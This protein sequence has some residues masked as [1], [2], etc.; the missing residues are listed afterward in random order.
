MLRLFPNSMKHSDS[1]KHSQKK[2]E[3]LTIGAL[4]FDSIRSPAGEVDQIIGGA[5]NYFSIA[6]SFFSRIH[7]VGIVG[8]DFPKEHLTLLSDRG[9]DV[10]GV[11]V[12]QDG[13][14][15]HWVGEY[16]ENLNEAKTLSTR[17]NV[18]ERFNPVLNSG[19]KASHTVFLANNDPGLQG[20]IL[21]QMTDPRFVG[22]D[23]MNFWITGKHEDL[24]KVLRRVDLLSINEGEACLLSKKKSLLES[25]RAVQAMGPSIL[26]IKR[27]EYGSALF[28]GDEIFLAPAYP[29]DRVIDPTGA[30]DSFAGALMGYLAEAGVDREW[31]RTNPKKLIHA[32]KRG[33]LFGS[34]MASFTVEDFGL[35]RLLRLTKE[36]LVKRHERL[37]QMIAVQD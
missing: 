19:Q 26:I 33:I 14:T 31:L 6:A 22:L 34:T 3:I 1:Q 17:L 15:F 5:G 30:G 8:N 4:A 13:Q 27:G 12:V 21:D 32:L 20:N 2:A 10:A 35:R 18:L 9:I 23:T 25:A 7:L 16:G 28:V 37:T 36:E 29:V 11:E 24:T